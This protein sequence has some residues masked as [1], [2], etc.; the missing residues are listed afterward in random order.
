MV[1]RIFPFAPVCGEWIGEAR[2]G[3]VSEPARRLLLLSRK[4]GGI[5][6]WCSDSEDGEQRVNGRLFG[7]S[8]DKVECLFLL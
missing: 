7:G 1:F 4:S 2:S 6:D 8:W 5:L 3:E